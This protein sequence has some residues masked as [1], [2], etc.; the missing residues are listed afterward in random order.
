MTEKTTAWDPVAELPDR[1][2]RRMKKKS[3]SVHKFAQELDLP[4]STL[5]SVLQRGP[6]K[7][8]FETV[9]RICEALEIDMY[10]LYCG[11]ILPAYHLWPRELDEVNSLDNTP[12]KP[13]EQLLV[14]KITEYLRDMRE[15]EK[16]AGDGHD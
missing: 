8:S 7:S 5:Q 16:I 4:Y 9:A 3:G 14:K 12:L 11:H 1:L 13:S 6:H 10:T 2:R 15:L